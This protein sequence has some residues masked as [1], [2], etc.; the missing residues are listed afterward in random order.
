MSYT[1]LTLEYAKGYKS[2]FKIQ[3]NF[4]MKGPLLTFLRGPGGDCHLATQ[5]SPPL[6]VKLKLNF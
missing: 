2:I 6:L 1:K 5:A 4:L 3:K